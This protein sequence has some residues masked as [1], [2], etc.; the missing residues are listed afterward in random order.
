MTVEYEPKPLKS[1]SSVQSWTHYEDKVSIPYIS[2]DDE[3]PIVNGIDPKG[4]WTEVKSSNL[5]LTVA[6]D[7]H[8]S[9]EASQHSTTTS[10]P[11]EQHVHADEN[12]PHAN[13]SNMQPVAVVGISCHFPGSINNLQ[14]F[15]DFCAK[16]EEAWSEF[17][18]DRFN[19]EAWYHPNPEKS[20]SVSL[21]SM[22]SSQNAESIA[23]R[24]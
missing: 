9:S 8:G 11:S 15:S 24:Y 19:I 14:D 6:N 3:E 16:G 7:V 12:R 23:A 17:P 21:G 1:Q 4:V 13:K 20:E 2:N 5:T 10:K 18:K 22:G